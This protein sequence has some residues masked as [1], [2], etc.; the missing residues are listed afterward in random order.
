MRLGIFHIKR[1]T[2]LLVFVWPMIESRF[3]QRKE[4]RQT[5]AV[6]PPEHLD[7]V[8]LQSPP[9]SPELTPQ[10]ILLIQ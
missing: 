7:S 2:T 6:C 8:R 1:D 5:H 3:P 9:A 10:R 4:V